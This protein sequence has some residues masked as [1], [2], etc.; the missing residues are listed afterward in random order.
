MLIRL[1]FESPHAVIASVVTRSMLATARAKAVFLI[2]L[3]AQT[4]VVLPWVTRLPHNLHLI[5]YF[6]SRPAGASLEIAF[7][8]VFN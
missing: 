6:E 1:D 8:T 2:A 7:L 4:V 3:C 5:D